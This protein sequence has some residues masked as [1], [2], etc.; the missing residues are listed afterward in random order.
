MKMRH[1]DRFVQSSG[2]GET[3]AFKIKGRAIFKILS[4][5]MYSD[6]IGTLQRELCSNAKD[7]MVAAGKGDEVYVVHLPTIL[8]PWYS[9][10]DFGIGLC[11]EDIMHV[12]TTY[13]ESLKSSD[14]EAI[15]GW[16]L[17]SK[18]PFAYTDQFTIE[19][20][21]E[22]KL[23]L[24]SCFVNEEGEPQITHLNTTSTLLCN[25]LTVTVPVAEQDIRE[26]KSKAEALHQYFDPHPR[27]NVELDIPE[28]VVILENEGSWAIYQNDRWSRNGEVKVIQGQVAYPLRMSNL[29]DIP[30][31][32]RSLIRSLHM[33]IHFPIGD[34]EVATNRE[35]L[36]YT[37]YTIKN[38]LNKLDEI[39]NEMSQTVTTSIAGC[40][41]LWS[42][43]I[44]AEEIKETL[45]SSEV[46][47]AILENV[48]F[49]GVKVH[50]GQVDMKQSTISEVWTGHIRY[51]M[52][53]SFENQTTSFRDL[54]RYCKWKV[55][56]LPHMRLYYSDGTCKKVPSTIKAHS[57]GR[58]RAEL[59][60]FEGARV[61][62]EKMLTYLGN[63]TYYDVAT[64]PV[65]AKQVREKGVSVA[66][67]IKLHNGARNWPWRDTE[68][69][70]T[71]GGVYVKLYKGII[72]TESHPTLTEWELSRKIKYLREIGALD[73][74]VYGVTGTYHKRLDT[75]KKVW[76]AFED[77]YDKAVK[78]RQGKVRNR[79]LV[80]RYLLLY[81]IMTKGK[82]K[83][84]TTLYKGDT[85]EFRE[86]EL[87]NMLKD[88]KEYLLLHTKYRSNYKELSS[89]FTVD[90]VEVDRYTEVVEGVLKGYPLVASAIGKYHL[91]DAIKDEVTTILTN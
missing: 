27:T 30:D 69:D 55:K 32:H 78:K 29:T 20:R 11:F 35:G 74:V 28:R 19:G 63:P 31:Q 50:R 24:F 38:I 89:L 58:D 56:A 22:G 51:Q 91:D 88:Y 39:Y 82:I 67:P 59:V 64:L 42:A 79:E 45:G 48:E 33:D 71:D 65:P 5:G 6:K 25:G 15:G 26:F 90:H 21:W 75:N 36:Q 66:S 4:D 73:V 60:I 77:Y 9:V 54:D 80:K 87:N 76:V 23:M 40:D 68:H 81:D 2:L 52:A 44:K 1:E 70:L 62:W 85:I 72:H 46:A 12:Y 49:K 61:E 84:L 37:D 18:S 43:S 10:L 13:G 3:T 86:G 14:N 16:G 47:N 53:R 34:L 8:E 41:T 57:Q 7:A 83:D 17:G